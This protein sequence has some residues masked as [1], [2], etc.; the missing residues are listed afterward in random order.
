MSVQRSSSLIPP[1]S[2]LTVPR[3]ADPR[4]DGIQP[5]LDPLVAAIDLMD[6]VDDALALRAEGGEQQGHAGADVGA[7]DL[8]AVQAVAADDDGAVRIAED[9]ARPHG[10]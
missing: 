1:P 6:V 9:D 7:G 3:P 10:D 5:L 2:S 8:C 4:A